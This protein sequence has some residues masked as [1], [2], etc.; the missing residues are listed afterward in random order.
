VRVGFVAVAGFS[1]PDKLTHNK[2]EKF[3][4]SL[5]FSC[6][7]LFLR[8]ERRARERRERKRRR[9]KERGERKREES[10]RGRRA[11]EGGGRKREES[12]K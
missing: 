6:S 8:E 5:S 12:K 1:L 2:G 10:E 9:A 3:F 11:K 4:F 7:F